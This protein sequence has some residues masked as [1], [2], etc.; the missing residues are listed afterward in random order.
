MRRTAI[1]LLLAAAGV[2]C[3]GTPLPP[4]VIVEACVLDGGDCIAGMYAGEDGVLIIRGRGLFQGFACDLGSDEPLPLAGSFAAWVGERPV[5]RL[6]PEAF[7][8]GE[9]EALRGYLGPGLRVG[10]HPLRVNTPSGQG[11]ELLDALLVANP[12]SLS[13]TT[14]NPYVPVGGRLLLSV[15]LQNLGRARLSAVRLLFSESGEGDLDLPGVQAPEPMGAQVGQRL[16]FEIPARAEG[17]V[18][19]R[20]FVQAVAAESV[21]LEAEGLW[22]VQVT[23]P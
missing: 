5:E 2:A 7:R 23:P 17:Q 16:D 11:A 3:E 20:A 13:G 6:V 4:P 10:L 21:P 8:E 15:Q 12:L 18:E 22:R 9:P 19:L 14:E 1:I